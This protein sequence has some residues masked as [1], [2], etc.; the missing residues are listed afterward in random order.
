MAKEKILLVWPNRNLS[1]TAEVLVGESFDTV[2]TFEK[3]PF[4]TELSGVFEQLG[5]LIDRIENMQS[6]LNLPLSPETHIEQFKKLLPEIVSEA[7]EIYTHIT[8]ENPWE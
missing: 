7:K 8:D 2:I 5:Q 6:A 3:D 1:T 4:V